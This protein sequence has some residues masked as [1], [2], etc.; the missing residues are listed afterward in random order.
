[1]CTK[2][3]E[4][5]FWNALDTLIIKYEP[6]ICDRVCANK[7]SSSNQHYYG[8]LDMYLFCFYTDVFLIIWV[9]QYEK[10]SVGQRC[11]MAFRYIIS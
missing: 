4:L 6:N 3:S 8:W 10:V 1:M 2:F 9:A 11:I 5:F 7:S